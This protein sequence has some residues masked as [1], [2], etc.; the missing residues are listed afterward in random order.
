M[1]MFSDKIYPY[2]ANALKIFEKKG[3]KQ[4]KNNSKEYKYFLLGENRIG[5]SIMKTF[6]KMHNEYVVVDYNPEIIKRLSGD[7]IP[8]IYGDISNIDFLEDLNF[9]KAKL[10]VSTI[11][12]METNILLLR[13]IRRVNKNAI[14]LVTAHEINETLELYNHGADYVMLSH[15]LGGDYMS[16]IIQQ[17]KGNRAKYK[18]HRINQKK[19]LNERLKR[20]QKHPNNEKNR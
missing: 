16:K 2:L 11:P 19:D 9:K 4:R 18:E 3:I 8:C 1:I 7:G 17:A 10:I 15:F 14:V 6:K 13:H 5:F 12:D 20:G